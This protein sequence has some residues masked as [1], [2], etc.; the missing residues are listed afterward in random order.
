[1]TSREIIKT[2]TGDE[3]IA[4]ELA[5]AGFVCVPRE[6]TVDMLHASYY[7]ALEEDA[8]AVWTTMIGVSEGLLTEEGMPVQKD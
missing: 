5:K 1:V 2:I 8:L 7:D 3:R 4:D 6:P